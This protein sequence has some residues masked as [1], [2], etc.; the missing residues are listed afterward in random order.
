VLSDGSEMTIDDHDEL[1]DII[2]SVIDECDEDD[3]ND[4]NDDD[5]DPDDSELFVELVK[6]EWIVGYFF[7]ETDKTS[8]FTDYKFTFSTDSTV[9]A[10]NG[11]NQINGT[12]DGKSEDNG[13]HE[14]EL[15][16]A[17]TALFVQLEDDWDVLDFD[18]KVI[19]LMDEDTVEGSKRFLN[20][21][22]P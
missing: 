5:E 14:L 16:F 17:E 7:N 12:W 9:I 4:H 1:E 3:D 6:G 8:D 22:R 20:F 10:D 11:S 18:G 13:S 21:E 19:K 2:E 15:K